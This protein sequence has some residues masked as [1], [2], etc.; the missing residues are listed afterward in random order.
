MW[1]SHCG[2]VGQMASLQR[3]G[4]DSIPAWHSGLKDPALLQ[5]RRRSQM[6]LKSNSWPATPHA[7][8]QG[9]QK[10]KKS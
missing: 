7:M 2:T 8:P 1:S 10:E 4:A 6:Q 9:G 5:L 3:Q